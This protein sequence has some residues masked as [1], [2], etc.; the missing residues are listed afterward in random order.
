MWHLSL[1]SDE[2]RVVGYRAMSPP[3]MEGA[4]MDIAVNTGR[5]QTV[6]ISIELKTVLRVVTVASGPEWTGFEKK[7]N[8]L[9][10]IQQ[11]EM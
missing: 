11:G 2:H 5:Q 8:I 9:P 6:P 10:A 3:V 7:M 1:A 4:P